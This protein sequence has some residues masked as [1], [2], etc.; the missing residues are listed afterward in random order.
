M[1]SILME[2]FEIPNDSSEE[3]QDLLKRLLKKNP[4]ERLGAIRDAAEISEHNFFKDIDFVKLERREIKPPF[5]KD[6]PF[7]FFD[8]NLVRKSTI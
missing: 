7:Q 1:K 8:Q 2:E 6:K 3:A 4:K 5:Y